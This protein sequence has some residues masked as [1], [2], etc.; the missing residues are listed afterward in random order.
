[1]S[2]SP[3][4]KMKTADG[5]AS[6]VV[7]EQSFPEGERVLVDELAVKMATGAQ[8]F[9]LI[10]CRWSLIRHG[11]FRMY[12]KLTPGIVAL[13]L[14]RKRF[15]QDVARQALEGGIH[16]VVSLG[17]GADTLLSRDASLAEH[18]CFEVDLPANIN[19]KKL[20]LERA[21]GSVPRHLSLIAVD[22]E[23]DDLA[24]K[25]RNAGFDPNKPTLFIWEAVTQYLTE[26]AVR[27]TFAFLG[28]AAPGSLVLFTYVQKAFLEGSEDYGM[29]LIR[30]MTAGD[31]PL[32]RFGLHQNQVQ[33]L[34]EPYGYRVLSNEGS[35][36]IDSRYTEGLQ[37]QFQV[38]NLE[39][40]AVIE[41]A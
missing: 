36:E 28:D 2:D 5:P 29:K 6:M 33:G 22:F 23:T 16:Q 7:F 35:A 1:M 11:L 37:R 10:L 15:I 17:A 34:V 30:K 41:K 27:S 14:C 13:F 32:W 3:A 39:P 18:D 40:I 12:E 20:A 21:L 8:R 4:G 26:E 9:W 38:S 24:G 31:S 25:L 19:R